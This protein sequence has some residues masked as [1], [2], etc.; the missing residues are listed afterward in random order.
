MPL[1]LDISSLNDNPSARGDITIGGSKSAFLGLL[2][3][4]G[5]H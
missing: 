4:Q 3:L 1:N 5:R 2:F